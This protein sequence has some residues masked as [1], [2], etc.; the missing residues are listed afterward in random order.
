[1]DRE[2]K[3]REAAAG[4]APV[5]GSSIAA[6]AGV[7]A[8]ATIIVR[9][10]GLLYRA[11]LTAI[12]GD[13]G[14]GYYGAAYNI[15]M[16]ILIL[17]SNSLPAAISR[18]MSTKI[19]VGEYKNAQRV[20]HC[21]LMYSLLVGAAGSVILY[22]GAGLLVKPNAIPVLRVF[23]PT[24]FLFGILG[25][26]RGY[27]QANQ[28]M[29]QTSVSQILE[30]IA[31]AAVSIGA[32]T[33]LIRTAAA[34]S[35]KTRLAVRGAMGSALGTG[36]GVA[37]AL[38]FMLIAYARHRG[39][40]MRRIRQDS[41]KTQPYGSIMKNTVL[42]I[43]PFIL[44]SF[45]LNLTT[46]LDQ[47]IY[48]NMLIDGRGLPEAAVTTVYGLFSNKA[49]VITNIPISVATAVSAAI[50]PNIATAHAT[51]DLKETRR[52]AAGASR[53][54]LVI[55]IPCAVGL[56]VLARPVTMLM[57]PQWDTL[58]LASVLLALQAVTVI[59]LSVGTITNAVLQAIGKMS[60][61]IVSAGVSL[62]I[63]TAALALFLKFTDWGIYSM[64]FVSV[65][66]AAIIFA[67]N[68]L[69]LRHYLGLQVDGARAYGIPV[70]S[71]LIMGAAASGVYRAVFSLALRFRGEYFANFV[72]VLPA[73]F[74][75]VP[76]YF[77]ILIRL[78]GFTE[79][80]ILGLPKGVTLTRLLKKL[81]WL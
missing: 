72:A 9:I 5:R 31:N 68:E 45:I 13:E 53:M 41:G 59:F 22:F 36:S 1:M 55:S 78:G 16:I 19:A 64:V 33:I 66:Y 73:I 71:A 37:T 43:T 70:L 18:Q 51:G 8:A 25:A 57:F 44:S 15:Y 49:V 4:K 80:D 3:N 40:F 74:V 65:L 69:F 38:V 52:R 34:S 12:I 61:P 54:A 32:A 79:E 20:F 56:M 17:S 11:P 75:A 7:L 21:A 30:Q 14:N 63:Q 6:Q 24:I 46:T 77:F 62:L 47:I 81:R 42:M 26:I 27:F 28:S 48:L 67:L 39:A 2:N 29:V 50:I 10:I 60:M 35:T 76:V 58:E 23:A